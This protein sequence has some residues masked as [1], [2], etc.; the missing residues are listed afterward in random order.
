MRFCGI[1]ATIVAAC[2]LAA[3]SPTQTDDEL[4]A[5]ELAS[6]H[7]TL[8]RVWQLP[9]HNHY[10]PNISIG[11]SDRLLSDEILDFVLGDS[12]D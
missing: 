11:T 7:D 3:C 1:L 5:N 9:G 2:S 6:E 12:Q 10:S 4:A 8:A